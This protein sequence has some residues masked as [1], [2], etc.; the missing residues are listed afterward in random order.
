MI[1]FSIILLALGFLV[2][3]SPA[4]SL[5]TDG[6]AVGIPPNGLWRATV[7]LPDDFGVVGGVTEF[8][9][10]TDCD[11]WCDLHYTKV[12]TDPQNPVTVPIYISSK[13]KQLGEK[14]NFKIEISA[15][16]LT[17][18][19]NYG[20]CV[21]GSA[22][23]NKGK[24]D[25]CKIV[26]VDNDAFSLSIFPDTIYTQPNR[27]VNYNISVYSQA[28]LEIELKSSTGNTWTVTTNPDER[29][30][31]TDKYTAG[32]DP[33]QITVEATI[34]NCK[35]S[36]FC[37]KTATTSVIPSSSPPTQAGGDF[38]IKI[39][40]PSIASKKGFS[41]SYSLDIT[42]FKKDKSYDIE[43][44]LPDG[45][46]SDFKPIK[47]KLIPGKDSVN[48]KLT[49]V[50]DQPSYT[51]QMKVASSEGIT[52]LTDATIN[53]NELVTD[54]GNGASTSGIDA[55]T[56]RKLNEFK[57]K[58]KDSDIGTQ[59]AAADDINKVSTSP[60]PTRSPTTTT[61]Q[62]LSGSNLFD[63]LMIII[64]AVVIV[65]ALVI[66]LVRKKKPVSSEEDE[67]SEGDYKWK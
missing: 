15:L 2:L 14:K 63:L 64:P 34:K 29:K 48:F 28:V 59:I 8:T 22:N 43:I 12:I 25:P 42:N 24:G 44:I 11:E 47:G 21:T 36:A 39:D 1:K 40:P 4:Y 57:T 65:L 60:K 3:A 51:F 56:I 61:S 62:P 6:A 13:N 17:N 35:N 32:T 38:T 58:Y 26:N 18:T 31:L 54:A 53:V 27:Q 23:T 33:E 46:E 67:D 41:V 52:K 7:E 49:P 30:V 10:K 20:V 16:G 55:D 45:L 5:L 9:V 66:L 19:Y 37:K 50:G